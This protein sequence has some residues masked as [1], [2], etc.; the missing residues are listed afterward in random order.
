MIGFATGRYSVLRGTKENEYGD[1]I[2]ANKV[3]YT[4]ILG[5]VVEKTKTAFDPATSRVATLRYLVGR[6]NHGSDIQDG[7]RIKDEKTGE[8]FVVGSISRPTNAIHK[9]DIVAD[10]TL[11]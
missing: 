7:D 2:D 8:I 4:G 9:S 5:S 1:E 10:L 6:F 11:S 3:V